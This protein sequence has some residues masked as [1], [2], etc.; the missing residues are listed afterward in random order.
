MKEKILSI[1][2]SWWEGCGVAA[3]DGSCFGH[4]AVIR[5]WASLAKIH[6]IRRAD[7]RFAVRLGRHRV[8]PRS[9]CAGDFSL[10]LG[11]DSPL[12]SLGKRRYRGIQ[13]S[14]LRHVCDLRKWVDECARWL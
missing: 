6:G 5:A 7:Q 3:C 9:Y 1:S 2:A 12:G 10:R 11:P 13:R 8:L 14:G 4:G